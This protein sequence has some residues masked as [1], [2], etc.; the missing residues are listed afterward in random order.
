MASCSTLAIRTP[1]LGKTPPRWFLTPSTAFHCLPSLPSPSH[2]LHPLLI[3]FHR[4]PSPS[5]AFHPLPCRYGVP[6]TLSLDSNLLEA[7]L[8]L[9]AESSGA[10]YAL[11]WKETNGQ[12]TV[13]GACVQSPCISRAC[14]HAIFRQPCSCCMK[15]PCISRACPPFP[16]SVPLLLL[17]ARTCHQHVSC[18]SSRRVARFARSGAQPQ[19]DSALLATAAPH[20]LPLTL[21]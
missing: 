15:S 19:T 20:Y 2:A 14:V 4:F 6:S 10:G 9:R 21:P 13:A 8:K 3:P 18:C 16:H 5:I 1:L 12:F 7:A 17:Q 11:Y